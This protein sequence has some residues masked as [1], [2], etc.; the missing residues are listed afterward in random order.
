MRL[1]GARFVFDDIMDGERERKSRMALATMLGT[2]PVFD[3]ACIG[4]SIHGLG[5]L[6][7]QA[8]ACLAS[9]D[10][11]FYYP[12]TPSHYELMKL[13]N[14]NVVNVHETFYVRGS[15]FNS[16]YS[17]IIEDVMQT[18]KSGKK[19]AYA[20]QGSPAFHCGTCVA[21][22]RKA[23][24][25]GFSSILVSG[26][27]SFELL[28]T[29]LAERYD[30]RNLQ[31]YTIPD[32]M[33]GALAISPCVPCLLFDLARYGLPAVREAATTLLRP[34]LIPFAD[35]LRATYPKDH[36]VM[37]MYVRG[38]GSC[39]K[40]ETNPVDLEDALMDFGTRF[41]A[42]PTIFAPATKNPK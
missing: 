23:K 10:I 37:L 8:L 21:L 33:D 22:Y 11:V 24:Q 5:A 29:V 32:L 17:A 13:I 20:T 31:L 28:S 30:L 26:V 25:E 15:D 2:T 7:F 12:L 34:K 18:V 1:D 41:G 4:T 36:E 42:V 14:D 9:A 39:L 16:A 27:S 6:T 3:L 40:L 35:V 38:D 19:V